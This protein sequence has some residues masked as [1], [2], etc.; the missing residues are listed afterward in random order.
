MVT[1]QMDHNWIVLEAESAIFRALLEKAE[2]TH[3]VTPMPDD[4][5]FLRLL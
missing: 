5:K 3:V 2:Q 1:K 4:N